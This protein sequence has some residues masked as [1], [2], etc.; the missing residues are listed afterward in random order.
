MTELDKKMD[1][2]TGAIISS[3]VTLNFYEKIKYT[4]F[5]RHGLKRALNF[6]IKELIKVE[7]AEYDKIYEADDNQTGG[8]TDNVTNTINLLTK[9][10]FTAFVTIGSIY[11]A[12][13][14][15]PKSIEGIAK[16]IL[17]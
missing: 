10:G 4:N 1:Y 5:F 9:D 15:D 12:W 11:A 17:K 7:S 8:I 13:K 14:K 16:K 6:A 2:L 3:Q